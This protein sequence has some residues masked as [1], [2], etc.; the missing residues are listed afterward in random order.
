MIDITQSEIAVEPMLIE[1]KLEETRRRLLD[2]TRRNRLLNHRGKGRSALRI[3]DELPEQIFRL[4]VAEGRTLQFLAREEASP[5]AKAVVDAEAAKEAAEAR[6]QA[7]KSYQTMDLALAPIALDSGLA[8]RH[9]DANLQ[10]VLEGEKLQAQL[11]YLARETASA[12]LEQGTN[13]LF[14]TLGIVEWREVEH[15]PT[16][17]A[18]LV[19]VPVDLDRRNVQS[20]YSLRLFEDEVI[21]NPCLVELCKRTFG[22]DLPRIEGDEPTDLLSYFSHISAA[23]SR[24]HGWK[25][26]AELHL[27]LFSFSKLLMYR[28]LDPANWPSGHTLTDHPI[29]RRLSGVDLNDPGPGIETADPTTLDDT[30]RPVDTFQVVDADSSQ[31]V[32]ILLAKRGASAV[33]EGPPG[34]GKSQTITNIIAECMAAGKTV[35]FVAEKSAALSVVKR[36]LESAGLG[37]FVLELHSHKASKKTVLDEFQ[38]TLAAY[39]GVS[40][41]REV[42][43]HEL[44]T[45]RTSLN[46]YARDLHQPMGA[47]GLSPFVALSRTI[48]VADAPEANCQINDPLAWSPTQ[49]SNV[50]EQL[51]TLDRW[52]ARIGDETTHPW[53]GIGLTTC[54]LPTRQRVQ[55][56]L[57]A[58]IDAL[59]VLQDRHIADT[60]AAAVS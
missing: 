28:D 14:L 43:T 1:T 49:L 24:M 25:L 45:T 16:C 51:N 37:D 20:R 39:E 15:G 23:V 29:V 50:L 6:G 7:T 30:I 56:S 17:R 9:A 48:A 31:Q 3:V 10:T 5:E 47:L 22:F 44:E 19:F 33:I 35:L 11:L 53:S 57:Q 2:L 42:D 38:R 27:G 52:R 18:P 4:L 26:K 54:D 21:T 40:Q 58:L 34:T 55:R 8:A 13:T 46:A 36:R 12:R 32:A 41:V 59:R 60:C